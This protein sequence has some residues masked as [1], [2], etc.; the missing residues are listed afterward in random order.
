M[1]MQD[2]FREEINR[3]IA[4]QNDRKD[5]LQ[6]EVD[7]INKII[8][9]LRATLRVYDESHSKG[10]VQSKFIISPEELRANATSLKQAL[11]Y[12]AKYSPENTISYLNARDL[13][14]ASGLSEGKPVNVASQIHRTI[15]HSDEWEKVGAGKFRLKKENQSGNSSSTKKKAIISKPITVVAA[16]K[17]PVCTALF[18]SSSTSSAAMNVAKHIL[19]APDAAHSRWIESNGLDV[20]VLIKEGNYQ[21]LVNLLERYTNTI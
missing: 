5:S 3:L 13:I 10:V 15:S 17:C 1:I 14:L 18:G 11:K 21:A 2:D 6:R 9:N 4:G 12:I 16:M 7:S 19:S 20:N 8:E